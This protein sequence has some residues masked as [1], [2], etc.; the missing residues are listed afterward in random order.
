MPDGRVSDGPVSDGPLPAGR[1]ADREPT[2][3]RR[4]RRVTTKPPEGSD[5]TPQQEPDRHA[6]GENDARMRQEKPPHY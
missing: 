5:P 1:D 4:R 3:P 6:E 2:P